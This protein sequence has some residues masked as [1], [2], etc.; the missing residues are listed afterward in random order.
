VRNYDPERLVDGPS[1]WTDFENRPHRPEGVCEAADTVDIHSYRGPGMPKLN[2]RRVAFLGEFGGLGHR[3]EGH[4]WKPDAKGS[5]GYGGFE[6]TATREGLQN[7]YL[8]LMESLADFASRGLGGSVYTQ[9]TDVER[10]INGYLTYDR[11]V[12]KFDADVLRKAHERVFA[13]AVHAAKTP[14]KYVTVLPRYNTWRYRFDDA[15]AGWEKPGFDDSAWAVG[16]AG[17]GSRGI[18]DRPEAD[19]KTQTVWDTKKIFIR[20][21]FEY[22]PPKGVKPR[23]VYIDMRHDDVAT[24]YLNGEEILYRKG[25]IAVYNSFPAAPKALKLLKP[26]RNEIAISVTQEKFSQYIDAELVLQCE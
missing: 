20:K 12:L 18:G 17:F 13:E 15:P 23:A 7:V 16:K 2:P 19:G 1:G 10:E 9:T 3:V 22:N 14:L 5:W 6:D 8:G 11:K 26:G 25:F 21:T 24:V 4:L